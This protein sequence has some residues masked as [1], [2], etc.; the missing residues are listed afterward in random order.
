MNNNIYL[1]SGLSLLLIAFVIRWIGVTHVVWIPILG[2]AILMKGIFLMN[3]FRRKGF[4]M[5]L[6][7]MLI[8]IGVV[9]ILLSML[10]RYVYPVPIVWA[11]L[12]YGAIALKV[13][14]LVLMLSKKIKGSSTL[15]NLLP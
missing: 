12:F 13:S 5:S 8:L 2:I 14:G 9:L 10:F 15:F 11:I 1:Y 6:W 7:L 4:K 3:V